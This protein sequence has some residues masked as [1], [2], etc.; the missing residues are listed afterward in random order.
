MLSA[1]P[2]IHFVRPYFPGKVPDVREVKRFHNVK[3]VDR[4]LFFPP[5]P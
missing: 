1:L 2:A 4:L 3:V 5:P